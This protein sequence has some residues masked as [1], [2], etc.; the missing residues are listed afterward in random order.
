MSRLPSGK[1]FTGTTFKPAIAADLERFSL[2][3]KSDSM[4]KNRSPQGSF[5][6]R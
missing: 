2:K 5:R 4:R 1:L 3:E 6:G